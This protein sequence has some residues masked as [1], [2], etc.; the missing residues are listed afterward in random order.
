MRRSVDFHSPEPTDVVVSSAGDDMPPM[1]WVVAISDDYE[2][3]E[4][5]VVLT[6]EEVGQAGYGLT[7]HLPPAVARRMRAAIRAALL[8]VGADPG[9]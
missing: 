6:L 9:A 5:R 4:P 1:S 2:D 8:E 3:D 7:A